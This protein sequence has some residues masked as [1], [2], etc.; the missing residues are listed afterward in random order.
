MNTLFKT[1]GKVEHSEAEEVSMCP[2]YEDQDNVGQENQ[3]DFNYRT[4]I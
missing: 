3:I 4:E 1:S 2:L